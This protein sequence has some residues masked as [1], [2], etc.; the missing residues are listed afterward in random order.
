MIDLNKL[1]GCRCKTRGGEYAWVLKRIQPDCFLGCN[2]DGGTQLKW[3]STNGLYRSG[4][5]FPWDLIS[6]APPEDGYSND[7]ALMQLNMGNSVLHR[8]CN[9]SIFFPKDKKCLRILELDNGWLPY[10]QKH[11]ITID[12]KEIEITDEVWNK[13]KEVIK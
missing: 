9:P 4:E 1:I 11:T 6:H 10:E 3:Y 13:L 5:S 8:K 7:W 12:G 2:E